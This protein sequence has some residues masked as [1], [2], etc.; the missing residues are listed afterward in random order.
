MFD[1]WPGLIED[2]KL[3]EVRFRVPFRALFITGIFCIYQ[4]NIILLLFIIYLLNVIAGVLT[5][6]S[7]WKLKH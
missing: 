1:S 3:I 2:M 7:F 5:Y 6:N 4:F